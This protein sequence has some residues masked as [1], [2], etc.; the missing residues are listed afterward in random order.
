MQTELLNSVKAGEFNFTAPR[1][2]YLLR[3][4]AGK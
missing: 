4:T 1:G 3:I 2:D